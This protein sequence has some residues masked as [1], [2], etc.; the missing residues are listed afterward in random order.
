MISSKTKLYFI[1][2]I[3]LLTIYCNAGPR[4]LSAPSHNDATAPDDA[5]PRSLA[6]RAIAGGAIIVAAIIA[7]AVVVG[8]CCCRKRTLTLVTDNDF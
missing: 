2:I 6:I 4:G 5:G 3:V 1:L 7:F 8:C